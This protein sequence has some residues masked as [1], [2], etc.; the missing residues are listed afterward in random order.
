MKIKRYFHSFL[1]AMLAL[2]VVGS[3]SPDEYSLGDINVT[4]DD[5]VEGIAYTITK[6]AANPNIVYL[7]SLM[8]TSYTILWDHP[9][10]REQAN[11]VTL[12]IPFNGEYQVRMGVETRGG[13]VYG[14]YANFTISDFCADFV[15][16]PLW[17]ALAGGAGNSKRWYI[18][19]DSKGLCRYF[20]GPIYFYGTNDSWTSVTDGVAV[21]GD[22][23]SW[24][25][26]WKGNEWCMG[27]DGDA[28]KGERD[29]GYMEFDL[30]GGAHV[31][32]VNNDMNKVYEGSYML[33]TDNHT[34][35]FTDAPMLHSAGMDAAVADWFNTKVLALDDSHMQLGVVRTTDPCLLSH[36]FI[37]EEYRDNWAP[38]VDD[39]PVVPALDANWRDYVEPVTSKVM[40]YKLSGENPF[41][42]CN[43]DGTNKNI[44]DFAAIDDA[45]DMKIAFD[46]ND[47]TLTV[48][49]P[50][51]D[52]SK[53]TYSLSDDGIYT[54]S[55]PLPTVQLSTSGNAPFMSANN[56]LRIMSYAI[57]DYSGSIKDLW[58]GCP[59]YDDQGTLYQYM[60]YHF[61]LQTGGEEVK[62]WTANLY[63]NNSGWGWT[64]GANG[65]ANYESEPVYVTGDG[66]YTF[67]FV[68]A[69]SDPYLLYIDFK[70][71]LKENPNCDVT[72]TSIKVDGNPLEFD[73]T[74]IP[75]G[76]GD[77]AGIF[78][79][80]VL[81]PW[82]GDPKP[83][84][85][86]S[87]FVCT[88]GIEVTV[89]VK[90]DTGA[91]VVVPE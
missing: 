27:H 35:K 79:R 81:N 15:S 14:P 82:Q 61:V 49:T 62:R 16:D 19:L 52:V 36:N 46:R 38:E 30:I 32:V 18:D 68:G 58:L 8:P 13:I 86:S 66:T 31:T 25:A 7:K 55:D 28:D 23:W 89:Y 88:S 50:A 42:W 33:D 39:T 56:T 74:L 4:E 59:Q 84:P 85:D 1:A 60:A 67:N 90:L 40:T 6:D 77:D 47:G 51:G 37:S 64:H 34:L 80:Y 69:E 53:V 71:M 91:P 48:T 12:K 63:F 43:L 45:A 41:D 3:C 87:V 70:K 21:G 22:S 78:R 75:R 26:G 5:L 9:Q 24:A 76:T 10:G 2:V 73:D 44:T 17:T 11:E 65:D 83:F 29:Y 54:F 20:D 57:D 72:I